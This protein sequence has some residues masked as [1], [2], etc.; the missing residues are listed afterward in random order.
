MYYSQ[1]NGQFEFFDEKEQ[2]YY[3][4]SVSDDQ[5]AE[6]LNLDPDYDKEAFDEL[7][8]ELHEGPIS[9]DRLS[10]LR[11]CYDNRERR[12][13]GTGISIDEDGFC[14]TVWQNSE[15]CDHGPYSDFISWDQL[16]RAKAAFSK[17]LEEE[18][19]K[20]PNALINVDGKNFR[21]TCGANVFKKLTDGKYD[22][23]GCRAIW[24]GEE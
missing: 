22:C 21:C 24:K 20:L 1:N 15:W 13:G 23:N 18:H 19:N 8:Q 7:M 3:I 17:A 9:S 5:F 14:V 11:E 12:W 6:F 4:M 10:E 16:N 2:E